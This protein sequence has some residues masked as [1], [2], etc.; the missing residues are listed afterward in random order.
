MTFHARIMNLSG[1]SDP[2][3]GGPFAN[4]YKNGHR[5]AR[6]AAA[7]LALQADA[8]IDGLRE[9]LAFMVANIGQPVSLET[10]EGFA[11]ARA[12]AGASDEAR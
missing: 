11:R 12:L 1:E 8:E 6:H 2:R 10:R 7:E 9:A 5:A 4:G 3:D